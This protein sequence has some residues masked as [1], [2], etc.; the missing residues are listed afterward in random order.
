MTLDEIIAKAGGVTELAKIAEVHHAT[1]SATWRRKG[2]VPV[3]RAQRISIALSI[4]LHEMR[5]DIWAA[6]AEPTPE[7]A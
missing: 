3:E 6:P 5:P 4:P 7:A 2:R 1:I